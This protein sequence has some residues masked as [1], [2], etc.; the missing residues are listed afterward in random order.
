M[1]ALLGLA[2]VAL[3]LRQAVAA[4]SP[5]LGDIRVDIPIPNIGAGLDGGIVGV[6][7][8][9]PAAVVAPV[10]EQWGWRFSLGM[11]SAT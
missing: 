1:T 7:T 2:L 11:W 5:V 10:A 3:T 8:A 9:V 4:V 6:S